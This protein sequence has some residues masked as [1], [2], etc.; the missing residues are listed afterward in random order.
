MSDD[1]YTVEIVGPEGKKVVALSAAQVD[2]F[3]KAGM[4]PYSA[5]AYLAYCDLWTR[6]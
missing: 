3:T 4:E 2:Y 1:I 5:A 6:A